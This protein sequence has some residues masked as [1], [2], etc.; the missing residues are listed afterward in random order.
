[1]KLGENE[2]RGGG[3]IEMIQV[4]LWATR[5]AEERSQ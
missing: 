3:R 5:L 4:R 2:D 1:M